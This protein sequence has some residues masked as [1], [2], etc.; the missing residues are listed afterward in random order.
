MSNVSATVI[1]QRRKRRNRTV[2]FASLVAASALFL[3]ACSSD[4]GESSDATGGDSK[5]TIGVSFPTVEGPFFT[6]ALYGITEEAAALGYDVTIVSA[7]GYGNVD[8]QV[9]QVDDLIQQ[10]VSGILLGAADP[11]ALAPSIDAAIAADIPVV[12]AGEVLDGAVSSV[13]ASHCTLGTQMAEGVAEVLPAGGTLAALKG[14]AGAFW[15]EDRW[16]CFARDLPA[17]V[18][19]IA[20][21]SS[22]PSSAEGLKLAEDILQANPDVDIF[23][24]VDDTVGVGAA[25]AIQQG[26][27]C[28][29]VGVVTAILGTQAEELLVE[30]CIDYLVAQ[31]VVEIGRLSVQAVVE[32]IEGGTPEELIEVDNVIVTVETL[33]TVDIA[34]LRQPE[35]W[36]PQVS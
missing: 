20:E 27:G 11:D 8:T 30:G 13:S 34:A 31:Q 10:G 2:R 33:P 7:G 5:G 4:S 16:E 1:T 3:G 35:G 23:Y 29:N 6:A 32:A 12:A 17:N 9:G 14:P 26:P 22:E 18:E 36:K 21:Q 15:A 24:G 25:Q 28:D 19:I